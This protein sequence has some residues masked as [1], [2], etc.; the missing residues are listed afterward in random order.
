M[1]E[2]AN[3]GPTM[4]KLNRFYFASDFSV[5][6]RSLNINFSICLSTFLKLSTVLVLHL[7]CFLTLIS[8]CEQVGKMFLVGQFL[9]GLTSLS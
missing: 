9:I 8:Y 1:L 6:Y 2:L 3:F 4:P 5:L 7:I